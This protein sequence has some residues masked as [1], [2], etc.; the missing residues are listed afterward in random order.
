MGNVSKNAAGGGVVPRLVISLTTVLF[1]VTSCSEGVRGS[2]G[3][4]ETR[5]TRN[6]RGLPRVTLGGEAS[7]YNGGV[8]VIGYVF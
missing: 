5:L 2:C 6:I 7:R 8:S 1:V 3:A 4:R